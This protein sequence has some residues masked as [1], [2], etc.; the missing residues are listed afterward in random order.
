MNALV[1][2]DPMDEPGEDR[3]EVRLREA[4]GVRAHLMGEMRAFD[5]RERGTSVTIMAL[6]AG[7]APL[8]HAPWTLGAGLVGLGLTGLQAVA[9]NRRRR[10]AAQSRLVYSA[11]VAGRWSPTATSTLL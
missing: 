1:T 8:D 7:A 5:W 2:R 11:L 6:A 9:A 10:R 3:L 4:E